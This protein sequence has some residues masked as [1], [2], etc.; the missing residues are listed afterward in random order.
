M[1]RLKKNT[2]HG[3][4]VRPG[5]GVLI[6]DNGACGRL[7]CAGNRFFLFETIKTQ[8]AN[9]RGGTLLILNAW[10]KPHTSSGHAIFARWYLTAVKQSGGDC[11]FVDI[12]L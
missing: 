1:F 7:S 9:K 4:K 8:V 12:V 5:G 10:P 11:C 3:R 2:K 6:I